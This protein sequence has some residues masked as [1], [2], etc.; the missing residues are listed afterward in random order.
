MNAQ[1]HANLHQRPTATLTDGTHA[2][3][4]LHGTRAVGA[5]QTLRRGTMN[6]ITELSFLLY[7]C[8]YVCMY[9]EILM[10]AQQLTA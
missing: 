10:F 3:A 6:G 8:M 7:V 2:L 1:H 4:L 5:S 9:V